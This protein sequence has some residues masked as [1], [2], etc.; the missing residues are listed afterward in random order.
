[1]YPFRS[2]VER[3]WRE[4]PCRC[5]VVGAGSLQLFAPLVFLIS[6]SCAVCM[7]LNSPAMMVGVPASTAPQLEEVVFVDPRSNVHADYIYA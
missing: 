3:V 5:I 4:P 2:R 1:M 7:A 6:Y